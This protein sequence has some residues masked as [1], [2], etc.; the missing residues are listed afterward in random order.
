MCI[1]TKVAS[2]QTP[3]VAPA[4]TGFW[5]R[6]GVC[7]KG[8][9]RGY[10]QDVIGE[11]GSLKPGI[12]KNFKQG[13]SVLKGAKLEQLQFHEADFRGGDL[14]HAIFWL[15]TF[16]E[17]NASGANFQGADFRGASLRHSYFDGADFRGAN[18]SGVKATGS[19]FRG[20]DFR[21]ANLVSAL[22]RYCHFEGADLGGA[23]LTDAVVALT[24]LKGARFDSRTKL[25]FSRE[26]ALARG[27][28]ENADE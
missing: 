26:V 27:M 17:T 20:G 25:P 19:Y 12:Y 10:N 16:A 11:C 6:D 21:N 14:A 4:Q 5:F 9:L 23:D 28:V 18:L 24:D 22:L 8:D 13:N 3:A 2:A 15:T 1:A 7:S